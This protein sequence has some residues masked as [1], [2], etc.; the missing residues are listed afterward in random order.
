MSHIH[1]HSIAVRLA[2]FAHCGI[3]RY[4][5]ILV[6]I[7]SWT[8]V[9]IGDILIKTTSI[10]ARGYPRIGS[11]IVPNLRRIVVAIFDFPN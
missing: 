8:T 2:V 6:D 4:Q 10:A 9:E 1:I 3:F 11:A 7:I 5:H